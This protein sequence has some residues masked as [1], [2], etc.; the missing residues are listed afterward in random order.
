VGFLGLSH[1]LLYGV[2]AFLL[3]YIPFVGATG[4]IEIENLIMPSGNEAPKPEETTID[5]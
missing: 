2:A 1:P 4:G 3:H 5:A